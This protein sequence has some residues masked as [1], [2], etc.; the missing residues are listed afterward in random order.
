MEKVDKT[1]VK[2]RT[3]LYSVAGKGISLHSGQMVCMRIHPASENT[4]IVFRRVDLDPVVEIPAR[5]SYVSAT[6]SC[7]AIAKDGAEVQTI[8]HLL[9][10]FAG[11]GIDNAIV[12]VDG[13]EVP[14]MDGSASVFVLLIKSAGIQELP[15]SK[16]FIKIKKPIYA[17]DED[18]YVS[19][20]PSDDNGF[21]IK[22]SIDFYDEFNSLHPLSAHHDFSTSSFV[23]DISRS[24]TFGFASDFQQM[25]DQ[26][27]ARGASLRNAIQILQ[28]GTVANIGGLRSK[29]ELVRHKILDAFGDLSLLGC[30]LIGRFESY[31]SGHELNNKLLKNLFKE[32]DSWEMVTFDRNEDLRI[33]Y[34]YFPTAID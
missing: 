5:V 23:Q 28:D 27:L 21:S 1:M 26:G 29:E 17:H 33:K 30:G 8:E 12:D 6:Q 24:R 13:R 19:L 3:L 31:K 11:F 4:G 7:T 25:I 15:A 22:F 32:K 2:Q 18:K 14:A 34:D 20:S 9:S 10:A 16:T